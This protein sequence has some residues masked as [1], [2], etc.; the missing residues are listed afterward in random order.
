MEEKG[1]NCPEMQPSL[2]EFHDN[3][4]LNRLQTLLSQVLLSWIVIIV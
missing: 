1:E 3:R 4:V 2:G